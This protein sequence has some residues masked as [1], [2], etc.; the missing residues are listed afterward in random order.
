MEI[1]LEVSGNFHGNISKKCIMGWALLAGP[2]R[3]RRIIH[4]ANPATGVVHQIRG[5]VASP[6]PSCTTGVS[7]LR[8]LESELGHFAVLQNYLELVWDGIYFAALYRT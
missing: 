1:C 4:H 5:V 8:Y 3:S 7:E 6:L 2:I